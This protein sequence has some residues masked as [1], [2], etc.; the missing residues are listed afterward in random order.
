LYEVLD[1][2]EVAGCC[3]RIFL[4]TGGSVGGDYNVAVEGN[5]WDITRTF[6]FD[7]DSEQHMRNFAQKVAIDEEYRKTCTWGTAD[8]S[9][10]SELY[11][12]ASS[13]VFN[14]FQS[15]GLLR[16]VVG[17]KAEKHRYDKANE[18]LEH[19]CRELY[20]GLKKA[21][22][23]GEDSQLVINETMKKAEKHALH[24]NRDISLD[25]PHNA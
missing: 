15:R 19:L 16:Y 6:Y 13:K 2:Y 23:K 24:L 18:I 1:K 3:V 4:D 17:Q 11:E 8:W 21:I 14:V 9:R 12:N 22:A 5:G 20:Y 25:H 10:V 7:E